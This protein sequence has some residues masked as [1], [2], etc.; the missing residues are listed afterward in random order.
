VDEAKAE[1]KKL[2]PPS[3]AFVLISKIVRPS[4][5]SVVTARKVTM[6]TRPFFPFD[7]DWPFEGRNP[8]KEFERR[9]GREREQKIQALGSGVVV[10]KEGHVLTNNHVVEGAE[11]LTVVLH[12]ESKFSAELVGTDP[13]TD[14]AVIKLKDCP[15]EKIVPAKLGESEKLE[16]GDWVLAVGAPFGLAQSVSAGIVSA[17]GRANLEIIKTPYRYENYIQT[18]AAINRGN[19]GGPLVNYKAEVVGI[20]IAIASGSGFYDGVCFAISSQIAKNVGTWAS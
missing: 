3:R 11:E 6:R 9:Y 1:L 7:D 14:L 12:D 20:N 19:S 18:D 17:T 16:V 2:G 8:F 15:A 13:K 5:V 10:S 4:V